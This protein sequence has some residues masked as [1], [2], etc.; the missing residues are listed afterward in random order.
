M[1]YIILI[2]LINF[3]SPLSV[4]ASTFEERLP[5]DKRRKFAIQA[6]GQ[7]PGLEDQIVTWVTEHPFRKI[8]VCNYL[9]ALTKHLKTCRTDVTSHPPAPAVPV[10]EGDP[11]DSIPDAS[12][13][14]LVPTPLSPAV[15]DPLAKALTE[16]WAINSHEVLKAVHGHDGSIEASDLDTLLDIIRVTLAPEAMTDLQ[17]ALSDIIEEDDAAA[18][19][20]PPYGGG[21]GGGL[22]PPEMVVDA[23]PAPFAEAL[24]R[25]MVDSGKHAAARS[26]LNPLGL[27]EKSAAEVWAILRGDPRISTLFDIANEGDTLYL[28]TYFSEYA[29]VGIPPELTVLG[30]LAETHTKQLV[31]A[32]EAIRGIKNGAGIHD[33]NKKTTCNHMQ[34]IRHCFKHL[35]LDDGLPALKDIKREASK[36]PNHKAALQILEAKRGL[37][38][39]KELNMTGANAL[40]YTYALATVADRLRHEPLFIPNFYF[41]VAQNKLEGGGCADGV[42]GRCMLVALDALYYLHEAGVL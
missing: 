6:L 37:G 31:A 12:P 33:V 42:V 19:P 36:Y 13:P 30:R 34:I 22:M 2:L 39:S 17:K 23:A 35:K 28:A 10:A 41:Y 5:N 26:I 9:K 4:F 16:A 14:A 3:S 40:R 1:K 38:N 32:R 25:I 29:P 27:W 8:K 11:R 18:A 24:H 21:G 20:A 15:P 7:H